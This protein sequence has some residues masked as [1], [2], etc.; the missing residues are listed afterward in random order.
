SP[1]TGRRLGNWRS[2]FQSLIGRAQ[3]LIEGFFYIQPHRFQSLIGRAQ[4]ALLDSRIVEMGSFE[5]LIGR[6]Q[7]CSGRRSEE[8]TSE[9]QSREYLAW[10]RPLVKTNKNTT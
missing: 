9:L 7:T 3:T 4:T 1:L 2:W 6:A 5:S 8:H 10:R